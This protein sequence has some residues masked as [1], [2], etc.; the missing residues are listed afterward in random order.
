MRS[1]VLA[2][3]SPYRRKL[4]QQLE[5]PFITASPV[6]QE[7]IDQRVAPELLVKH[8]AFHKAESL[9]KHFPDSLIIGA[10][11]VFV[12]A[13]KRILGKPETFDGAMEQLRNMCGKAHTFFTGLAVYDSRTGEAEVD[14]VPYTVTL[15]VLSDSQIRSYLSRENPLDCAGAFK[16]E[17]L[18]IS[19]MERM[20]G[21]DYTSLIGLPLIKLTQFLTRFG[22]EVL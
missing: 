16:I 15:R 3:T 4:L 6:Y 17:G 2:S 21:E 20:E 12:D 10:D 13:R 19:L 7:T 9:R 1:V 11:Q 22:V 5:I 8:L 18:G 14:F